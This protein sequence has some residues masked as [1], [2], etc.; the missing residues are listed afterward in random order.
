MW[1]TKITRGDLSEEPSAIGLLTRRIAQASPLGE[2]EQQLLAASLGHSRIYPAKSEISVMHDGQPHPKLIVSGW[3]SRERVLR[4]GRRQLLSLL[5]PGDL[6]GN[7]SMEGALDL[8]ETV[9]VSDVLVVSLERLMRGIE[10][11]PEQYPG[12]IGGLSA[13][14]LS[15]ER[16]LLEHMARLGLPAPQRLANLLIELFARCQE[17]GITQ[18]NSFVM[19]LGQEELSNALGLS[20]VHMNRVIGDLKARKLISMRAGLLTIEDAQGLALLAG[21]PSA[22]GTAG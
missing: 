12:I 1:G 13:L 7:W 9:A 3:A 14:R 15:E 16:R 10:E 22:S 21:S 18:G 6:I 19:P 4:N 11:S 2:S 20:L 17:V 5:L 8:E